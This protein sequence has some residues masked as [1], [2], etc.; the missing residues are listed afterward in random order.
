MRILRVA[1]LVALGAPVLLGAQSP[2]TPGEL[3]NGTMKAGEQQTVVLA[4]EA[5]ECARLDLDTELRFSLSLRKPP[6]ARSRCQRCAT[7]SSRRRTSTTV[8]SGRFAKWS[9]STIAAATSANTTSQHRLRDRQAQSHRTADRRSRSVSRPAADRS[10][11]RAAARTIRSPAAIRAERREHAGRA[12][13]CDGR[14]RGARSLP[15]DPGRRAAR[16]ATAGRLPPV[17]HAL[18]SSA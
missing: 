4:L 13:A 9:S 1:V 18:Y 6:T 17:A 7:S 11:R 8:D 10:A 16:R 2:L 15:R 14:R 5:G 12:A 3:R